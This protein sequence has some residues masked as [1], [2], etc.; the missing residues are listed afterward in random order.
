M[1]P[2]ALVLGAGGMLGH[3]L[4]QRLQPVM[5][6]WATVRTRAGLPGEL[7]DSPRVLEGVDA[8]AFETV[9]AALRRVRPTVVVNCVGIVKQR[10]E[11][12]A[13]VPSI[14]INALLPH[15][16]HDACREA[17]AR[18]IHVS[19]D[20]V[21]SGARGGYRESDLPDATDLYGR[22]K[23]LGEVT[24]ESALTLRTS[25]IG[26][27]LRGASGLVE[28][29]L[30]QHGG[31]AAGFTRAVFSGVTTAVLATLVR[32]VITRHQRLSGL[33]HVAAAPIAKYD[34]LCALNRAF[35]AGV[36]IEPSDAVAIDRSLDGSAL[37][38]AIGWSAP[39]W[40][41][42]TTGLAGD[43]T[44]YDDWRQRVS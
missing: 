17:G 9:D 7:F 12:K 29:F 41:E 15:R 22:S 18:L 26:R 34:L 40:D 28:W 23:L 21:F 43:T 5:D 3:K 20:C 14:T 30:S 38:G 8:F 24:G 37:A 39:E 6:T 31:R 10:A 13:P 35:G 25:I 44:P 27:E 4:W 42:M 33:F 19:T 11:A 36:R 1:T 32:D 2:R 16:L